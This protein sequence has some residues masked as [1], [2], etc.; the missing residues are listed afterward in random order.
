MVQ[1]RPVLSSDEARGGEIVLR[2]RL[3]RA[4]FIAGLAAA[5]LLG[6]GLAL[7]NFWR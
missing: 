5:G 2:T 1:H 4:V 6:I 7:W 3:E